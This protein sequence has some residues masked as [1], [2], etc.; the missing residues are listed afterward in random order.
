MILML[1]GKFFHSER[2]RVLIAS[3]SSGFSLNPT[4]T[5]LDDLSRQ[6]HSLACVRSCLPFSIRGSLTA[7]C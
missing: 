6:A 5:T 2:H 1:V 4:I 7:A 3:T